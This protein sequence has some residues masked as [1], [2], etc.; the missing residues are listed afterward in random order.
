MRLTGCNA[1]VAWN[2]FV[3]GAMSREEHGDL[4]LGA[5]F[6]P[7]D[8][9]L[10]HYL[11]LATVELSSSGA[12]V[13]ITKPVAVQHLLQNTVRG[14]WWVYRVS[15]PSRHVWL[16]VGGIV[17]PHHPV[18]FVCRCAATACDSAI[19]DVCAALTRVCPDAGLAHLASV[20]AH[21]K[22]DR[23]CVASRGYCADEHLPRHRAPS[24][25]RRRRLHVNESDGRSSVGAG[26]VAVVPAAANPS[27]ATA[28]KCCV[29]IAQMLSFASQ[30][31]LFVWHSLVSLI[32]NA[33]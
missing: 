9:L 32:T 22:H 24:V 8:E 19:V 30:L 2:K 21:E 6:Q 27:D 4:N 20:Q 29:A 11:A 13:I 28:C 31:L 18:T 26:H 3:S 16:V 5:W 15:A 1:Q 33:D 7:S 25:L 12:E 14:W 10:K 23:A 17:Y